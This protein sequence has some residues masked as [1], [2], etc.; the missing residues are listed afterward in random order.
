MRANS[1]QDAGNAEGFFGAGGAEEYKDD[2]VEVRS[3]VALTKDG[4]DTSYN[5]AISIRLNCS[6]SPHV[7]QFI[8]REIHGRD[9]QPKRRRVKTAAGAY[10]TTTN[11][12]H[13]VWNTDSAAKP[14]PYYEASGAAHAGPGWL[15]VYDQP[16]V[17]PGAGETWRATFK[18]YLICGG[19]V[20][21]EVTWVRSQEYGHSPRYS[22]TVIKTDRL[23]D[24][25]SKQLKDQ[26]YRVVP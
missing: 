2:V 10:D 6:V 1:E 3:G 14:E 11:A 12:N 25:A 16:T 22:V 21:R 4:V 26:G 18:A 23:P 15:T 17:T 13:P 24:W 7:L 20:L 5:D 19:E 9:G 8:Y